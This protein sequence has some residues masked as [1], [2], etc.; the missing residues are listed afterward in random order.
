ML[1]CD[2]SLVGYDFSAVRNGFFVVIYGWDM[3]RNDFFMVIYG[4]GVVKNDFSAVIY[5]LGTVR[6]D[7]GAVRNGSTMVA[8]IHAVQPRIVIKKPRDYRGF[9]F[10]S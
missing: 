6:N 4:L 7:F 9:W 1:N 2:F 5:A 3:I 10:P 8:A